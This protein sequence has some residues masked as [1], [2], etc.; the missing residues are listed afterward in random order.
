VD[1]S[2]QDVPFRQWMTSLY[3]RRS[4]PPAVQARLA[5]VI[6]SGPRPSRKTGARESDGAHRTT[7]RR[8]QGPGRLRGPQIQSLV[9]R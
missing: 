5:A 3:R 8:F 7:K 1:R 2:R 6:E 4:V 9:S